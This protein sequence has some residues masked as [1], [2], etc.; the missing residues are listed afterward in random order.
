MNSI[1]KQAHFDLIQID[2]NTLHDSHF[3]RSISTFYRPVGAYYQTLSMQPR[4]GTSYLGYSGLK[5]KI[6]C[7]VVFIM[8]VLM[9]I[10]GC[11]LAPFPLSREYFIPISEIN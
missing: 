11:H 6:Y 9:Q 5:Y 2:T 1:L 8:S 7:T 3:V 4:V 10:W